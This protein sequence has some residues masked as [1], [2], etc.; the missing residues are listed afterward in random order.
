[1]ATIASLKITTQALDL[2]E[3]IRRGRASILDLAEDIRR[4]GASIRETHDAIAAGL[5]QA[6]SISKVHDAIAAGAEQ[7]A[8]IFTPILTIRPFG[9]LADLPPFGGLVA[10]FVGE[11][12]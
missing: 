9:G 6:A 8:R 2:A 12:A 5:E 1:M 4:V 10:P 3:D 7:A 11:G